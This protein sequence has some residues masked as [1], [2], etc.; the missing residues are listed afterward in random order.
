M[1][2]LIVAE[3]TPRLNKLASF[4]RTAASDHHWLSAVTGSFT[5][6]IDKFDTKALT[7]RYRLRD[8]AKL[9]R[10]VGMAADVDAVYLAMDTTPRG[11]LLAA[12]VAEYLLSRYPDRQVY[13]L[14]L[15]SLTLEHFR[16]AFADV[17]PVGSGGAEQ[18]RV[19]R[20]INHLVGSRVETLTGRPS[21]RAVLPLTA[22]LAEL[23]RTGRSRMRVR[24]TSGVEF[25]SDFAETARVA[26]VAER[27]QKWGEVPRLVIT[28]RNETLAPP[29]LYSTEG[30]QHDACLVL[31]VRAIEA[32]S[33]TA[34]L[35]D[36][37]YL[38][39]FHPIDDRYRTEAREELEGFGDVVGDGPVG[40]G[41]VPVHL[42]CLPSDVP[43]PV[44]C[45]YRIVWANTL[46]SFGCA[47]QMEV[48]DAEF[49]VDGLR[50]RAS[51]YVPQSRGFDRAS[52]GLFYRRGRIGKTRAIENRRMFG[53]GPF[54]YELIAGL[55]LPVDNP[56]YVIKAASNLEYI[57]FDG[58]ETVLM[59]H[60]RFVLDTVGKSIPQLLDRD[61]FASTETFLKSQHDPGE[62]VEP[63]ATWADA[64]LKP[65]KKREI[66]Y[67][68]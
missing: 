10:V 48:E 53:G 61:L 3:A 50:F 1:H 39:R 63:W 15:R 33:Q 25:T 56:A 62:L 45:L 40:T 5:V 20:I 14:Q 18:M 60:G 30:L 54:E 6:T 32:A 59:D 4:A 29:S 42:R 55:G 11:D 9:N 36:A 44:R 41:V 22:R 37:G 16:E 17:T 34:Q 31:G 35:Y 19:S 47:M 66:A 49:V 57:G 8:K 65:V 7:A 68:R 13:R 12:D 28:K 23:E 64:V 24:L 2:A 52:L 43:K 58:I 38:A 26:T 46:C 51:S 21:G 27:L 67:L